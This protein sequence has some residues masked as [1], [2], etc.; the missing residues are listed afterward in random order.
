MEDNCNTIFLPFFLL[1]KPNLSI[2]PEARIPN[3]QNRPYL[4][5]RLVH[6]NLP[7]IIFTCHNFCKYRETKMINFLDKQALFGRLVQDNLLL[8]THYS[9]HLQVNLSRYQQ[10]N[11]SN[12]FYK[13]WCNTILLYPHFLAGYS[14]TPGRLVYYNLSGLLLRLFDL[15]PY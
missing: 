11:I 13:D 12:L 6:H 9:F 8:P 2:Y 7:P 4:F 15:L 1:I 5:G 14:S 10:A 3:L